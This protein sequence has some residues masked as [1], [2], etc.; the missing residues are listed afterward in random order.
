MTVRPAS[1]HAV[2]TLFLGEDH[3]PDPASLGNSGGVIRG[4]LVE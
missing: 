1:D 4:S 2:L 3:N